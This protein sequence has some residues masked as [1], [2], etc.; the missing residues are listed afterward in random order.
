MTARGNET[1]GLKVLFLSALQIH[2]PRSGGTLRSFGLVNALRRHGLDVRVHSLTGRKADYL[3][4]RPSS[5]QVWPDGA[6]ERVDR[7]LGSLVDWLAGYV[8]APPP[9]WISARLA[10]GASS[11]GERLLPRALRQQL[12]W[13]DAIVADFPFCA[14]V[15]RAPSARGKLRVLSTHNVEHHLIDARRGARHRLAR[16][17]VRRLEVRAARAC[18]VLV[19]CCAEDARFFEAHARVPRAVVVPN[20]VDPGRF[21]GWEADRA[22]LRREL[23]VAAG[24]KLLLF[25]GSRWGPNREAFDYLRAFSRAHAPLLEDHGLH[26]LVVGNVAPG[27]L[28]QPRFTATGPVERVE[29]YFAAA[30]AGINPLLEGAGTNLKTCEFIAARLPMLTTPFGARGFHVAEGESGFLFDRSEL[31]AVLARFADAFDHDPARLRQMAD[32]AYARNELLVDMNAGV[33]GLVEAMRASAAARRTPA[34]RL[35]GA[36]VIPRLEADG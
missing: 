1:G 24:D 27:P 21:R 13:C 16:A 30:D 14:P 34:T 23:G 3:A 35:Q 18:D 36:A 26:L 29:P 11:P 17:L 15:L 32:A 12:R 8:V 25:T 7:G 10:A 31:P 33:R 4:R 6:E 20:G 2:P 9:V 22:A 19:S 5:V 28:R